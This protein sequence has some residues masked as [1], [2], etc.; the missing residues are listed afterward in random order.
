M[1]F[2]YFIII[3]WKRAALNMNKPWITFTRECLVWLAL[4]FVDAFSLFSYYFPWKMEGP[5]I[6]IK[7]NF[8][9]P[10]MCRTK[11]GWHWPNGFGRRRFLI[12]VKVFSLFRYYFPLEQGMTLHLNLEFPLPKKDL[13]QVW[14]KSEEV[15]NVKSLQTD[16]QTAGQTDSRTDGRTD[17]QTDR[18]TDTT[19]SSYKT[20]ALHLEYRIAFSECTNKFFFYFYHLQVQVVKTNFQFCTTSDVMDWPLVYLLVLSILREPIDQSIVH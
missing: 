18:Q 10:G 5:F 15:E 11:F 16:R 6:W 20:D 9:H 3:P 4:N 19:F 14:L 8:L 1:Y 13:C 2:H 12:F 7:L 17:R